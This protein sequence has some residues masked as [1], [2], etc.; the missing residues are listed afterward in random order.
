MTKLNR[1]TST[2]FMP[3]CL[4]C[5]KRFK[6][7]V[8]KCMVISFSFMVDEF[9]RKRETYY[10][11]DKFCSGCLDL[12]K[13]LGPRKFLDETLDEDNKNKKDNKKDNK[14]KNTK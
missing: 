3:T 5:H 8:K 11:V 12:M 1:P 10:K 14:R 6:V 4:K 9:K 7:P 2:Y 13:I